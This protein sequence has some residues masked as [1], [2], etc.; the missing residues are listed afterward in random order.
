MRRRPPRCSPAGSARGTRS[1]SIVSGGNVD[2]ERV[3]ALFAPGAAERGREGSVRQR[4][5]RPRA[6]PDGDV[7]PPHGRGA[8]RARAR[9]RRPAAAQHDVAARPLGT[10]R[11]D[12]GLSGRA[13]ELRSQGRRGDARQPRHAVRLAPGRRDALRDRARRA[14]R[15]HRRDGDHRDPHRRGVRRRHRRAGARRTRATSRSSARACRRART[16]RRCGSCARSAAC[17]CGAARGPTPSASRA[18]RARAQASRSRWRAAPRTPCAAPT[19]S[20]RR[21]RRASPSSRARGSRPARTSTPSARASRQPRARHRGRPPV[22]LLHRSPRV[23]LNEAGDFLIARAEGAI[24]DDHIAGRAGRRSPRQ[25][26]GRVSPDE[27]TLFKSLGIAV[28]DLAAA[29]HIHRA[30]ATPAAERGSS[31]AARAELA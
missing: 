22:A 17:A 5:G 20:A 16:W 12:A 13:A 3:L 29:H 21:P 28:E 11:A 6:P 25:V 14:A 26:P 9:R 27:I 4:G 19:S 2:P 24:G 15:D 8:R 1:S 10:A 30:R 7:H 18:R 31:G 23:G